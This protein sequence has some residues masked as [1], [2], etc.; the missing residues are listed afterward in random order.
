[1]PDMGISAGLERLAIMGGTFDPIH[2]GH[3]A[4]AEEVRERFALDQVLFI[5]TGQPPH[6]KNYPVSPA[7]DRFEMTTL[8]VSDNPHFVVSRLEIDRPGTSYTVDTLRELRA[9]LGPR[10]EI[11]F[12]TGADAVLEI[13]TWRE[14]EAILRE[15][16]L[17]AVHRPG[18]DLERIAE[19]IGAEK[20]AR[21]DLL[22]TRELD[23]SSTDLRARVAAGRSLRY[24]TPDP[25]IGYIE[26]RGLYRP[27]QPGQPK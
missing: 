5:P 4:V 11:F 14:P 19:E 6:K 10:C 3:L 17:I 18:Y 25:V 8:A 22:T 13:L 21:V 7:A 12:I 24:L 15:C 2:Y 27:A 26:R 23:I 1:M 16:R 9:I 20:A